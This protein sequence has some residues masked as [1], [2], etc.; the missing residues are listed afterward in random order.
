MRV[1]FFRR[2]LKIF[3]KR[4]L[5]SSCLSVSPYVRMEQPGSHSKDFHEMLYSSIFPKSNEQIEVSLKS[6][7]NNGYPT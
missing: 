1:Q 2:V 6:D 3:L 5:A 4:L 7:K